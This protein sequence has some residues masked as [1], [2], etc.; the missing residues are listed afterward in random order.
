MGGHDALLN[1]AEDTHGQARST[2]SDRSAHSRVPVLAALD[3]WLPRVQP[4][5]PPGQIT[6]VT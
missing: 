3:A 4:A 1:V 6:R 5:R 2:S